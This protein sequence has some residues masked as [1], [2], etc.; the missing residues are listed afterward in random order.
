MD[1]NDMFVDSEVHETSV[2]I[3]PGKTVTLYLRQVDMVT[4]RKF[5]RAERSEDE[6]MRAASVATLIADSLCEPDGK[7]SMDATR[8]RALK[9]RAA[10]AIV[11]AIMNLNGFGDSGKKPLPAEGES[12]LSTS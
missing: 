10:S 1:N 12:G 9:P 3:S 4:F 8:A 5:Q 7:K 2:E 6:D 11:E